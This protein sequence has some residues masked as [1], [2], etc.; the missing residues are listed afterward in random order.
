M[1]TTTGQLLR[2]AR[3]KRQ[4]TLEQ[5]SQATHIRLHYLQAL[6]AD[7]LDSL[8][9]I[10]QAK[11]FIRIYA[12]FLN[13]D[14]DLLADQFDV[15]DKKVVTPA[16][17]SSEIAS[18]PQKPKDHRVEKIFQEIG[19]AL[20]DQR[21]LLGLTL[22]EVE[23]H[24]HL[25]LHYLQAL[26]SGKLEAL[27]SP[28]QGRGMLSNYAGFLGMDEDQ[29]L[30][31]FA[32]G[33]QA[34]LNQRRAVVTEQ[35]DQPEKEKLVLP[36]RLRRFFSSEVIISGTVIA[37]LIL[38]VLW[39][40]IRVFSL[41]SEQSPTTTAPSISDIL[42]A[43]STATLTFTPT[44]EAPTKPADQALF[45]TQPL[46][47]DAETGE[48]ILPEASGKVQV[49]L[50]VRQRTWLKVWVDGEVVFEGRVLPGSAYSYAGEAQVEILVSSGSAIQV[51]YN[52]QD[53]GTPGLYGQV[54][55]QIYTLEGILAPTPT[56]T[57]D[58][59]S[60]RHSARNPGKATA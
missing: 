37:G 51:F 42:L 3:E 21:E 43:S 11:G 25:K 15:P 5:A 19:Q 55:N 9:S 2:Q 52:Q 17:G 14:F 38:F 31:R 23:K 10:T 12:S 13:L 34:S 54:V 44:P 30:L 6:E 48:I 58:S 60:H 47:T 16:T 56:I 24:T 18:T 50:S 59:A 26:E 53:L 8:P 41:R 4:L 29:L 33:L 57:S 35:S 40:A 22:E 7:R 39:G 45:P 46:A 32:E 28:V 49:N 36:P 1:N 20:R 27:P